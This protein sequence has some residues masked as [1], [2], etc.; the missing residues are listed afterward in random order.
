MSHTAERIQQGNFIYMLI[1]LLVLLVLAPAL[2]KYFPDGTGLSIQL[3]FM[4]IMLIG[5]WSLQGN[6]RWFSL[7]VFLAVSG[8]AL[9]AINFF[10][11][12]Q[13]I[14]LLSLCVVLIFCILSV[15]TAMR[16]IL[17]SGRITT[18][19]LIGSVCIYLLLGVIW[20]L[21]YSF[22]ALL[23]VDA[24]N[25]MPIQLG[26]QV[27]WEYIYFSFVTLS[28]LGYGDISPAS[29]IARSLVYLEAICG[30]FYI[31][32]LVASLVGAHM[33]EQAENKG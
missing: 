12:S 22:I 5:V 3:T 25:G 10:I 33:S 15:I 31:A 19:K 30:Q 1:G 28:T 23:T 18:N 14:H 11:Q 9:S 6:K 29:E 8:V 26:H 32:I 2:T 27:I 20:A 24:F 21:L 4:S 17:F 13:N 7:G 16:Q